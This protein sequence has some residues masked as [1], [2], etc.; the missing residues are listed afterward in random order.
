MTKMRTRSVLAVALLVAGC[1][2]RPNATIPASSAI[3]PSVAPSSGA[4]PPA[5][6]PPAP[7][8]SGPTHFGA[9]TPRPANAACKQLPKGG[10]PELAPLA[11]ALRRLSCEPALFMLSSVALRTELALPAEHVVEMSGPS[12]VS[13][14]FP[15][16]RAAD[17]A[18]AL[19]VGSAVAARSKEGAWSWRIWNLVS[20]PSGKLELWAPGTMVIGVDVDGAKIDDKTDR[21]P[22][23]DVA[24]EGFASVTMPESVLPVR[25]DETAVTMLLA[26]LQRLAV[27][28][29]QLTREPKDAARF[30][31]LDDERFRVSTRSSHEDD[32]V[33]KGLDIWTARTRVAAGPVIEGLAL[34]G[35]IEHSRAHDSD[36]YLLFVGGKTKHAWRGLEL[37]LRFD[38]RDG[39]AAPGPYG[40]YVLAGVTLMPAR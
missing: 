12:T 8:P 38:R 29:G 37:A 25:D 28:Q 5:L 32:V 36:E 31:G 17:L 14:R 16:A 20:A 19:G 26:G 27:D 7:A 21:V 24:L 15:K 30:A 33:T 34:A 39:A 11:R 23:G 6:V 9:A 4:A 13:L 18:R 2:E 1:P 3:S 10:R 35:A 40:G 22:L